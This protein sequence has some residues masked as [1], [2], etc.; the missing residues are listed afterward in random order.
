MTTLSAQ[1][2]PP[3]TGT[4]RAERLWGIITPGGLVLAAVLGAAMAGLFFF[5]LSSQALYSWTHSGDWGHAFAVPAIS[6]YL[7]WQRRAE[8]ARTASMVYWPGLALVAMAIACYVFFLAGVKNHMGQGWAAILCVFGAVLWLCGPGIA[9]IAFL[10]I[11]YLA[12]GITISDR[13]MNVVTWPLQLVATQGAHVLLTMIGVTSDIAG[14]RITVMNSAGVEIPL[15]VAEACSGM[16]MVIAF[17]ALGAAVGLVAVKPWWQRIVLIALGVPVAI[18]MNVVRVAVLGVASLS[19]PD[20]AAG[21]AHMMIGTLLLVPGFMLYIGI[22]WALKTAVPERSSAAARVPPAPLETVES[23]EPGGGSLAARLRGVLTPAALTAVVMLGVSAVS[24]SAAVGALGIHLRKF[25]IAAEG[26]RKVTALPRETEH[27]IAV[28]KD[29][30][31]SEE[32]V[33]ELGTSNYL[34]RYYEEKKAEGGGAGA[35]PRRVE[36]HLAYYTGMIDTV[37]HVPDRCMVG[38]GW[39]ITNGP[40]DMPMA[41]NTERFMPMSEVPVAKW[42]GEVFTARVGGLRVVLPRD[43][44]SMAL[45]VTRFIDPSGQHMLHSGY[46]F[47]AN[48]GHVSSPEGVRLLA[49]QDSDTFAYYL[50]VQISSADVANEAELAQLG[51][52]LLNDLLPEIMRC[53]PDWVDVAAG[54]YPSAEE[55]AKVGLAPAAAGP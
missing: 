13:V 10:P 2:A 22:V 23:A 12:M 45:R 31:L 8:L 9:K 18:L 54:R 39:S 19:N 20:L 43:P 27:W 47:I 34:S 1:L 16:R 29:T 26:G 32:V 30:L 46:F 24:L 51:G 33:D 50:K 36:L 11:A 52:A 4:P 14:N 38:A 28:G 21:G 53:V 35:R 25:P 55:R 44:K 3:I 49:F 37:P 42:K 17:V 7:L 6:F 5:F 41:L 40:S 15:N 48:G